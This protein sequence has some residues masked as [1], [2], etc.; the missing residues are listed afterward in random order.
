MYGH[1]WTAGGELESEP[2]AAVV[3]EAVGICSNRPLAHGAQVIRRVRSAS[4]GIRDPGSAH[5]V[6]PADD[7]QREQVFRSGVSLFYAASLGAIRQSLQRLLADAWVTVEDQPDGKRMKRVYTV[8]SGGVEAFHAWMT[9]PIEDRRIETVALSKLHLLGALPDKAD[10]VA[11]LESIVQRARSDEAS[12]PAEH[13]RRGRRTVDTYDRGWTAPDGLWNEQRMHGL[14][15]RCGDVVSGTVEN[16]GRFFDRFDHV[17][18]LSAP[19]VLFERATTRK[20]N[21]YGRTAEQQA[22]IRR[23]VTEIEPLLRILSGCIPR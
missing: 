22:E 1:E 13:A 2:A 10:R 12:L 23:Y 20:G 11:A 4:R 21:P 17:G 15:E 18:L 16:Q 6:R 9:G 5:R 3:K 8:T 7:L 19:E 14:L